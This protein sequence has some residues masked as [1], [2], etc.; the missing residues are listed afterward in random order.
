MKN[1]IYKRLERDEEL[2]LR[3]TLNEVDKVRA[4]KMII[5][6]LWCIYTN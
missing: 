1:W 2:G 6:N 4:R 3:S 5:V